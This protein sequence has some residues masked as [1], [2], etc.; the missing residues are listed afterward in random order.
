MAATT[1][2]TTAAIGDVTL[3]TGENLSLQVSQEDEDWRKLIP[4]KRF[5]TADVTDPRKGS[6]EEYSLKKE[7]LRGIY[8]K[9]WEHPSPV[10][11][12]SIPMAISGYDILARAKNGVGK[13]GSYLIPILEKVDTTQN[14]TQALVLVPTIELASQTFTVCKALGKYIKGLSVRMIRGG[15][16][17]RDDIVNLQTQ[18]NHIIVATPGR[19]A[20]VTQHGNAKLDRLQMVVLDEADKLLSVD[21]FPVIEEIF[22]PM[23]ATK[24]TL[25]CSA[26][27]PSLVKG[28]CDKYLRNYKDVNVMNELCLRGVT[29]YYAHV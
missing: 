19:M 5:H 4:E 3:P 16:P 24:Q 21:F 6:F 29:H 25:L 18:P 20:D 23:P 27:Y 9:R 10:Q 11:E 7:L 14:F 12:D 8:A 13:T 22:R 17:L 26:T 15:T 2:D 1:K 28:F